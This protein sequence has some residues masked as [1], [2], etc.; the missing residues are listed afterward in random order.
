MVAH[1]QTTDDRVPRIVR[2][3][4]ADVDAETRRVARDFVG[5]GFCPNEAMRR[6]RIMNEVA[7]SWAESAVRW[8]SRHD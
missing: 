1:S 3:N 4:V 8:Y 6:A 5:M 7:L 2:K